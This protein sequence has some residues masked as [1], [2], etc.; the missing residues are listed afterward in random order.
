MFLILFV[1]NDAE[2]L[3]EILDAWEKI[4]VPGV[5]IL[6]STGLG[7]RRQ[8]PGIWDDLPLMP[9]LQSLLEHEELFSR[10][11]FTVV[12]DEAMIQ[13]LVDAA[14]NVV[15]SLDQPETGLVVVLPVSK[16]YGLAKIRKS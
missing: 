11:L 16:V 10:T 15:G 6:R 12:S 14:E 7:R 13:E 4:G 8:K 2:R 9:S 3:E 1:L 5:T